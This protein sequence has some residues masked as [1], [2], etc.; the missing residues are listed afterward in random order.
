MFIFVGD[1]RTRCKKM[2]LTSLI[3]EIMVQTR[4]SI[5]CRKLREYLIALCWYFS[6]RNEGEGL[7]GAGGFIAPA[8]EIDEITDATTRARN[9]I[10]LELRRDHEKAGNGLRI[11]GNRVEFMADRIVITKEGVNREIVKIVGSETYEYG[12]N[13]YQTADIRAND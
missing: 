11:F 2:T 3:D 7:E 10:Y 5:E 1:E 4:G 13:L 6:E 9:S 12:D 8:K